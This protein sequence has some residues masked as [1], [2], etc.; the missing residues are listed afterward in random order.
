M[1]DSDSNNS[2]Q[3]IIMTD[4]EL[5]SFWEQIGVVFQ[6]DIEPELAARVLRDLENNFSV[7][8]WENCEHLLALSEM[9]KGKLQTLHDHIFSLRHSKSVTPESNQYV[10]FGLSLLADNLVSPDKIICMHIVIG[11]LILCAFSDNCRERVILGNHLAVIIL[12]HAHWFTAYCLLEAVLL[13]LNS[14][15]LST[16]PEFDVYRGTI[17]MNIGNALLELSGPMEALSAYDKTCALL[18]NESLRNCTELDENRAM[19]QVNRGIAL[20]KLNRLD[21][22]LA[23]FDTAWTIYKGESLKYRTELD[24]NRA[25]ILLNRGTALYEMDRLTES[26]LAYDTAWELLS[27]KNLRNRIELDDLRAKI[28]GN[29]GIVLD[30]LGRLEEAL[31]AYDTSWKLYQG[32]SLKDRLELDVDRA[33]NQMNRVSTLGKMRQSKKCLSAVD[34]ALA[35]LEGRNLRDRTELNDTRARVLV[36]RGVALVYLNKK[37]KAV[38]AF[39]MAWTL[40]Q[41]ESLKGRIDL[42]INRAFLCCNAI[43]LIS[44]MDRPH[45]WAF[46]RSQFLCQ[47]L[48]MAPAPDASDFYL[49]RHQKLRSYFVEF[50]AHWLAYSLET[51]A[52]DQ[53]PVILSTLQGRKLAGAILDELDQCELDPNTP[54]SVK[55]LKKLRLEIRTLDAN[56]REL[57]AGGGVDR[58]GDGGLR[59]TVLQERTVSPE[60]QQQ[61]GALCAERYQTFERY[62]QQRNRVA[63][64]EPDFQIIQPYHDRLRAEVLSRTLKPGQILAMLMDFSSGDQ[65]DI[66]LIQGVLLL[67]SEQPAAWHP[68]TGLHELVEKFNAYND[69]LSGRGLR[70]HRDVS[71]SETPSV[72]TMT[73]EQLVA[74]WPD[75]ATQMQRKFW[76]PLAGHLVGIEELIVIGHGRLYVLPIEAGAPEGLNIRHYP[77]LIFY[78][79]HQGLLDAAS[80]NLQPSQNESPL[81][82]L[83]IL[84]YPGAQGDIPCALVESDFLE[85]LWHSPPRREAQIGEAGLGWESI[86]SD[87][88][89]L[90]HIA[91]HGS[92]TDPDNPD[93]CRLDAGWRFDES[94]G[95]TEPLWITMPMLFRLG[96]QPE[97]VF[98]SACLAAQIAELDGDPL[99]IV[100]GFFLRGTRQLIGAVSPL[101]DVWMPVFSALFYQAL[102]NNPDHSL[103]NAL[104]IAKRRIGT[105]DWV[106]DIPLSTMLRNAFATRLENWYWD[107]ASP[108]SQASGSWQALWEGQLRTE[109]ERYGLSE[110]RLRSLERALQSIPRTDRRAFGRLCSLAVVDYVFEQK[111]PPAIYLDTL[112][113]AIRYYG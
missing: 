91:S 37:Q 8:V 100:S 20:G 15:P 110:E 72:P 50:H 26:L 28:Q 25:S 86:L 69:A 5:I 112:R 21:E 64:E 84:A 78:G 2:K 6:P 7:S 38:A 32:K 67:R 29:R 43:I 52:F 66:V 30:E 10:T 34:A 61:L 98:L 46:E 65:T 13:L 70:H 62:L 39:D 17:T 90:L 14:Q 83:G 102:L 35:L 76:Q 85:D 79:M 55:Q 51:K 63:A 82:Q 89:S 95:Q 31:D 113:Y 80:A 48:D 47:C 99:G 75:M 36:N 1:T 94:S 57:I 81:K 60:R 74:F 44:V 87:Q 93:L 68:L 16:A 96:P 104:A 101:P 27:G 9:S 88:Q 92:G 40:F 54:E 24:S 58:F 59:A 108:N 33:R 45:T 109:F 97:R 71:S 11:Q 18:Q 56:I 53:L 41:S 105:G 73:R 49:W 111:V 42:D 107:L 4:I 19:T 3:P 12:D 23:A 22:S 106:N 103:Y 77:G